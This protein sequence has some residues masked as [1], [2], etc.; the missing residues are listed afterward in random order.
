MSKISIKERERTGGRSFVGRLHD[1]SAY[2]NL[3]GHYDYLSRAYYVSQDYEN[4][5]ES[6]L[7]TCQEMLD[8][9]IPPLFLEK[10]SLAGLPIPEYFISN[11]HFEPPAVVDPLNPFTLKGKIVL[12]PGLVKSIAKSLT[13]NYTYAVCCQQIP[14][15]ARIIYFRSVLGWCVNPKYRDIS[16]Q[17]WNIFSIPLAK[18]RLIQINSHEYLYSDISPLFIED[19][20]KREKIY[21]EENISWVN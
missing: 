19:L 4:S 12:K 9:Y 10:A 14:P 3:A 1:S 13:R 15:D 8:A 6:I 18:V 21:L 20:S 2:I 11:G 16:E 5:G 7:P 17:I